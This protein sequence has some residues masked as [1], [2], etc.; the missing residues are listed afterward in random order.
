[1]MKK[2]LVLMLICLLCSCATANKDAS[3]AVTNEQKTESLRSKLSGD[4]IESMWGK[5]S[6]DSVGAD[7]QI[8]SQVVVFQLPRPF[9]PA[10]RNQKQGTFIIEFVPAGESVEKWSKMLTLIGYQDLAAFEAGIPGVFSRSMAGKFRSLCPDTFS[11]LELG[12]TK[13]DGYEA[14]ATVM[15]CGESA[16]TKGLN[17]EIALMITIK[18]E[19]DL[20]SIQWAERGQVSN[21]PLPIDERVWRAKLEKMKPIKLLP[22]LESSSNK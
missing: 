20:Y 10:Y 16:M 2:L 19:K 14:M 9:V 18:G 12:K 6:G 15:G 11:S 17:S 3:Q 8:F 7:I 1:M 13:I 22:L 4:S 5:L 21:R